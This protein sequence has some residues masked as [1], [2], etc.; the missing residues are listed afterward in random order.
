MRQPLWNKKTKV[1]RIMDKLRKSAHQ[2][3][4]DRAFYAFGS[5]GKIG[6]VKMGLEEWMWIFWC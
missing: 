3:R 5:E 4:G 2:Q 1:K 6:T